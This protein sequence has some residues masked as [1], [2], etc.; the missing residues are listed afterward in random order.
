MRDE[1]T[2][3]WRDSVV[4][5]LYVRSFADSDGDGIGDLRGVYSK[6]DYL[7]D[8]GVDA[9]WLNP[10]YPSPQIDAGYDV[11][12]Y[13]SVDPVFG[14]LDD[15]DAVLERA[16][17]LGL[18]VL[19]DLVP[20]HTSDQH[21]W[22]RQARS[23]APGSPERARYL[24]RDGRGLHGEEPPNDW[25]SNFGGS[26]WT[27]VREADG[28]PGQWY[29]HL[30]APE[31]P[32]LDW[33]NDE[34]RAEFESILRFWL[35]RGVDGFR[36]DV[37][38]GLAKDPGLPDL[39]G[40]LETG[41][42]AA[43]GHPHWDQDEVHEVYRAWRAVLDTYPGDP[44]FV[45]EIWVS[46]RDR[47]ARY[48]RPDELHTGFGFSF[49]VAPWTPARLRAAVDETLATVESVGAP[50]TWVLSNHDVM[51]S[52]SRFARPQTESS[53]YL[54]DQFIGEAGDLS[55]GSRRARAAALLMLALP[56]ACYLYQGEELGL[57]EVEDLPE[58]VLADPTWR[59]S[60]GRLRGRDG[61]RV[62]IP[63][64]GEKPPYGFSEGDVAEPWLPQPGDWG[65]YTV[66]AEQQQA[67]SMLN[68]YRAALRLRHESPA[69]GDGRMRWLD[70]PPDVLLF[71]REPGFAC[72]V[73][74]GAGAVELPRGSRIV[75]SSA[76]IPADGL[77]PQDTAVW[78]ETRPA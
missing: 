16:H 34:V 11:A 51:R 9:L 10:F 50:A 44:V 58:A 68:L 57:P 48:L 69:L 54:L 13:R 53:R 55:I 6:L 4:Y 3:W 67:D 71:A 25:Q 70:S 30:F 33:T 31:Q 5:Q 76:E 52:V 77:V 14:S 18:R 46:G 19:V 24:F 17:A 61:C 42:L 63:W 39:A 8:L 35:S 47:L 45:G 65:P 78:L 28:R 26:A 38:H 21:P 27:R 56:G 64:S 75:L 29:L 22:F 62:P 43:E 60:G 32:D 1:R 23:A 49:L 2:R 59:R 12:D 40:R 66:E 7:A 20:N 74:V 72:L 73:N 41:G 15:V 36:I 37:A